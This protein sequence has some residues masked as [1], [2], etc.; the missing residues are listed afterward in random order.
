MQGESG[1]V[2]QQREIGKGLDKDENVSGPASKDI[3]ACSVNYN[4]GNL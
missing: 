4:L 1:K 3:V 2:D